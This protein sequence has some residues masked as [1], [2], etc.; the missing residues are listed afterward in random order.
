MVIETFLI[1]YYTLLVLNLSTKSA[2]VKIWAWLQLGHTEN[3]G[4]VA[5]RAPLLKFLEITTGYGASTLILSPMQN[6]FT[7]RNA[8]AF[9]AK[10][11][12]MVRPSLQRDFHYKMKNKL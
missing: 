3:M 2:S 1:V 5:P 9:C 4:V 6:A 12:S 11:S 10:P 7:L 8:A